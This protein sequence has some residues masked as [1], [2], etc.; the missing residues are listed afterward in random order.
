MILGR[1]KRK[2]K[3]RKKSVTEHRPDDRILRTVILDSSKKENRITKDSKINAV[4][5]DKRASTNERKRG[6][7]IIWMG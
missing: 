7:R 2:R 4:S 6:I 5:I 3:R 1:R